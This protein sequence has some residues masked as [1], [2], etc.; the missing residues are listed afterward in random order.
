VV[1]SHLSRRTPPPGPSARQGS[2]IA[3]DGGFRA[4]PAGRQPSVTIRYFGGLLADAD[5]ARALFISGR[6]GGRAISPDLRDL[7]LGFVQHDKE[8]LI[9]IIDDSKKYLIDNRRRD[10]ILLIEWSPHT[11]S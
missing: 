10:K 3:H 4:R 7:G 5:Y 1:D 8:K 2:R 9:N 11:N 6:S